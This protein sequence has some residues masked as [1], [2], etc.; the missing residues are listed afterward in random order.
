MASIRVVL[1]LGLADGRGVGGDD[2]QLRLLGAEALQGGLVPQ[3][4][5]A[6]L[7]HKLQAR[8]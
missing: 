7:H 6:G 1:D 8:G 5:L 4:G 3:L 2:D